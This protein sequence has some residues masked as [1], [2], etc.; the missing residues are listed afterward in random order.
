MLLTCSVLY[1]SGPVEW[2]TTP[3]KPN[4]RSYME[5]IDVPAYE[6]FNFQCFITF[7]ASALHRISAFFTLPHHDGPGYY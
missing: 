4:E 6:I 2:V 5:A 1:P 7:A 3:R